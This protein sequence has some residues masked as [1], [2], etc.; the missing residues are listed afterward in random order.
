MLGVLS[1]LVACGNPG[2]DGCGG[3]GDIVSCVSVSS[4]VPQSAAGDDS[5]NVDAFFNTDCNADGIADDPEPFTDDNAEIT[6]S[7]DPFRD[8]SDSQSV[9][10][11]SV[12]ISYSLNSC[13]AGAICPPLPE[14]TQN[15][16]LVILPENTTP[17][18]FPFVPLRV[19]QAYANQ[20]GSPLAFPSY[21]ANYTFVVQTL[22]FAD[23]FTVEASAEFTIG[24][25]N[26]CP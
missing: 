23:T 19:K 6:F 10:V 24:S 4:I 21:S 25:F 16:S 7:N 11:R 18:I 22:G 1:I 2:G 20:G 12:T 8:A 3:E 14:T 9:A 5:S 15:V 26:L 13:P 17:G